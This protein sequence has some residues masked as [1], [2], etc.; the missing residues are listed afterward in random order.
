MLNI[1]LE[2]LGKL[3]T[4]ILEE[5]AEFKTMLDNIK[6]VNG[7]LAQYWQ[8]ADATKYKETVTEQAESMELL[9]STIEKCG[10]YLLE[11]KQQYANALAA[12][13]G[14]EE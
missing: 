10:N 8:G 4:K 3:G 7:E 9:H 14:E 12:N 13:L 5:A 2:E 11:A 1:N 6:T